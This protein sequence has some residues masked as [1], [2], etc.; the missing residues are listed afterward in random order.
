[1]KITRKQQISLAGLGYSRLLSF[2]RSDRPGPLGT[3][4]SHRFPFSRQG[5]S[6]ASW[7]KLNDKVGRLFILK[8]KS[9]CDLS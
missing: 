7:L 5:I 1:M 2:G 6:R 3:G 9:G 4:D 8:G